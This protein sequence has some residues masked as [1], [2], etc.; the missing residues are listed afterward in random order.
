MTVPD[1]TASSRVL[2]L[3]VDD[4]RIVE[5]SLRQLLAGFGDVE[6]IAEREAD[7]GLATAIARRPDVILQDLNMP[8]MDG[9]DQIRRFRATAE[10]ADTP[11]V[12]LSGTEAADTKARCFEA[13]ANDYLVKP[14]DATELVARIRYHARVGRAQRDRD[15]AQ[16]DLAASQAELR[17][18]ND[19]L[20]AANRRLALHAELLGQESQEQR[21]RFAEVAVLGA[22]LTQSQD[23]AEVMEQS[24]S[25]AR[26]F[27]DA[28]AGSI[29]IA[30]PEGLRLAYTQNDT[31]AAQLRPGERMP[32]VN[33]VIPVDASSIAGSA[34]VTGKPLRIEDVHSL[35]PS[36]PYR[37]NPEVDRRTG[38]RTRSMLVAPLRDPRGEALGVLQLIN[39]RGHGRSDPSAASFTAVD[40][41]AV[42]WFA[43]MAALALGR[44]KLVR[45]A[46]MRTIATAELRDPSETGAHVQRV[47][48]CSVAMYDRWAEL[49]GID[50]AERQRSRDELRFAAMLHDVGKVAIPDSILKKPGKLDDAEYRRIQTH[51]A[52]GGR[53]FCE[54]TTPY[55]AAA[56]DVVVHHHERWDGKGYPGAFAPGDLAAL[57]VE[58]QSL[59]AATPLAGEDIPLFARIVAVADVYDALTSRRSYKEPWSDEQVAELLRK[60]SG[61]HFDPE[62]VEIALGLLGFFRSVRERYASDAPH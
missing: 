36:L 52:L 38:Y 1:A 9:L 56:R 37:F 7:A 11:L 41:S 4:Q 12:V 26:R 8:G 54:A 57:P 33:T 43:G 19:E 5:A 35:D 31:L 44:A 61:R 18:R 21:E 24:L 39:A 58:L 6:L 55:D 29:W 10:L 27:T 2:V 59:P 60:E 25:I 22:R 32:L 15:R 23:L 50:D 49:H 3:L 28:D 51:T 13:G 14:P 45:G 46:I 62:I 16:R 30:E 42:E 48:E 20:D 47:S 34:A 40:E 17:R 53:L